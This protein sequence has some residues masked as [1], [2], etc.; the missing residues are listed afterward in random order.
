LS[1][2]EGKI[3]TFR[4]S[5]D[6]SIIISHLAGDVHKDDV[7]FAIDR[8]SLLK[9]ELFFSLVCYAEVWTGIELM[10]DE[11]KREQTASDFA[12][13]I[14]ASRLKLVADNVVI[15]KEAARAQAEYRRRG[16]RR[17]VLIPDFLIGANAVYYSG[18]LLTTNPRDFLRFFPSLEVLT[19]QIFLER[20]KD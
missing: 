20:Y 11:G 5:L 15:A 10:E 4:V 3:V 18:H 19:P 16:G 1:G 7:L 17:E 2:S 12:D 8:L 13:I 6:S 14:Q 9:A